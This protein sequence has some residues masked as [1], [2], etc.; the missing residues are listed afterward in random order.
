MT[1]SSDVACRSAKLSNTTYHSDSLS[2]K[3]PAINK[4]SE[5][6][7]QQ[8]LNVIG[9]RLEDDGTGVQRLRRSFMRSYTIPPDVRLSSISFDLTN[10]GYLIIKGSRKD[11]KK[12]DLTKHL[13]PAS[14]S[15]KSITNVA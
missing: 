2:T 13:A 5:T 7:H 9:E 10:N 3:L 1:S 6:L 14:I 11:W 8:M 15:N 12:T 4:S